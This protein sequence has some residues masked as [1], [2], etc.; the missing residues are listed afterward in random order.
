MADGTEQTTAVRPKP[1]GGSRKG[2]PNK[3]TTTAREAIAAFVDGNAHQLSDWLAQV[4][5]GIP[6]I[7][8]GKRVPGEFI[9]K[10]DPAKAFDMFQSVIEYHIPKLAR[11]EHANADGKAFRVIG[12]Q[13]GDEEL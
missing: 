2:I 10:P 6:K 3:A 12:L 8:D 4:S 5:E 11:T 7:E 13:P 9:V 1:P